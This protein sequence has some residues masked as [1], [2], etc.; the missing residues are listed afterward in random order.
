MGLRCVSTREEAAD[1]DL[2]FDA[3]GIYQAPD[4][5]A[6]RARL[7]KATMQLQF[8]QRSG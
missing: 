1:F 3:F 5:T 6:R 7:P 2:L 8:R 4:C